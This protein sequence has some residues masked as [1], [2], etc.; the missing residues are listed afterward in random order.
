M[1]AY[2]LES[3]AFP[4]GN[5]LSY[6]APIMFVTSMIVFHKPEIE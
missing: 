2:L 1:Q 3:I 5:V 6:M 4:N